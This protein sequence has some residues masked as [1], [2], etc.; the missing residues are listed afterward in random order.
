MLPH[1]P[2]DIPLQQCPHISL[3]HP[4]ASTPLPLN[5]L[6]LPLHPQDIPSPLL[7]APPTCLILCATYHP[8]AH[9]VSPTLPS[10]WPNPQHHLPSLCSCATLKIC[11]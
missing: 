4:H 3:T 7:T 6:M 9:I 5:M 11:L 1:R 10:H 2:Q 8:H